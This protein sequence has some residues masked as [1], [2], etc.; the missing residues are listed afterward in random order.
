MPTILRRVLR[1][2]LLL[3]VAFVLASCGG[4][5][6]NSESPEDLLDRAFSHG[7]Q[8]ADLKL[9]AEVDLKGLLADPI[10]LEAEGPFR[11]NVD[12]LPWTDID[13]MVGSG[14]GQTITSG[15]LTTGNR[16]FVK[17]EDVYFE[18]PAAEVRRANRAIRRSSQRSGRPLSALGLEPRSWLLDARIESDATVGGVETRHVSGALDVESL[19]RNLNRAARRWS[20]LLGGDSTSPAQMSRDDIRR[21]ARAAKAASFDVYVGKHD[22]I[23]R[24]ISGKIEFD[25]P[26][27]GRA[28][29]NGLEGGS[30]TFS[31]ELRDV[32]GDQTI[33]APESA[34]PLSEL[35]QSLGG[36]G[37]IGG[38]VAGGSDGSRP[39][40]PEDPS[41]PSSPEADAFRRYA[42]CLDKARSED[43]EQLQRCAD[44]LAQP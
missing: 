38:L 10:R 7:V 30:I 9:D 28:G 29:L 21:L 13:L 39:G 32:D 19:M 3:V 14:G 4:G 6:D 25:V 2:A 11:R 15:V 44:L 43:T 26:E 1:P 42:E 35:T 18:L 5:G 40:D 17:F 12:R 31:L 20:S 22:E 24:R 34:R 16:A 37:I 23:I 8:S 33:E 36:G 27:A 41:R